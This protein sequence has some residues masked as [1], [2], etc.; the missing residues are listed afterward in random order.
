MFGLK[1]LYK[2]NKEIALSQSITL[3]RINKYHKNFINRKSLFRKKNDQTIKIKSSKIT[4][5]NVNKSLT[6]FQTKNLIKKQFKC[7][8]KNDCYFSEN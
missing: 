3:M 8:L 2:I 7:Q 5:K 6:I 4:N 1:L